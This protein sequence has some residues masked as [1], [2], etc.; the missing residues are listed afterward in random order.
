MLPPE[1][2]GG[3]VSPGRAMVVGRNSAERRGGMA[4]R[5]VTQS[6]TRMAQIYLQAVALYSS[7]TSTSTSNGAG[8]SKGKEE[9]TG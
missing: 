5:L 1:P 3:A 2:V 8:K 4:Q 6:P 9:K 7:K